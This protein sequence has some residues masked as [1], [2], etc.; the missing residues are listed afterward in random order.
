MKWRNLIAGAAVLSLMT[1][2][3]GEA[4]GMRGDGN[5]D[6]KLSPAEVKAER[7]MFHATMDVDKDG[8]VKVEEFVAVLQNDF[9][10]RDTSQDGVLSADEFVVYWCGKGADQKAAK[11]KSVKP[12]STKKSM[13]Q[14]SDK[15]ADGVISEQ[16][17]VTFWSTR[18]GAMDI[19]KDVSISM[20]EF[21]KV[22]ALAAKNIDANKDG[23]IT[24]DE[25]AVFWSG[26]PQA[27]KA[28]GK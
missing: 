16:E 28:K 1:A 13:H 15:N 4:A 27:A 12:L 14:Q 23:V 21:L 2:A 18:F 5:N 6:V 26:S 8:K 19:N 22:I 24:V 11:T 10:S 7:V 17:C 3:S 9:K 20:D 25:Y